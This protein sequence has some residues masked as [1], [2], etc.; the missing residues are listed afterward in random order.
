MRARSP[1]LTLSAAVSVLD[2]REAVKLD[3]EQRAGDVDYGTHGRGYAQQR[4]T[5]PR[6]AAVIHNALGSARTVLN[7]GAGSGSY[8]P[9]DRHVLAVEPSAAMRMQRPAH[10]APAIRGVAEHLPFDDQSVDASMATVTVH[11]WRDLEKGLFEL[12]RVTRG[13]IVIL[14]FDPDALKRFWLVDYVPE[15]IAVEQRRFPSIDR[16]CGLLGD[17]TEV[18]P[19]CVPID[20][21]DGFSEAYYARPERFLDPDVLHSQSAWSFV[22]AEVRERFL[23]TLGDDLGSGEWDRKYGPWR[24]MPNFE[25][26]LRL[27]VRKPIR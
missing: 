20:C 19:I 9:E 21:V 18:R 11:Q 25:G 5:D 13:P 10:L 7:V 6:I 15:V 12:R 23:R 1:S 3:N 26:S 8:E 2:D 24:R 4:R 17:S 27:V 16:L 22:G 14:T